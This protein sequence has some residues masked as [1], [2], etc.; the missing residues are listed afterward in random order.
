MSEGKDYLA[1]VVSDLQVLSEKCSRDIKDKQ[2]VNNELYLNEYNR[3]LEEAKK[4]Q[5]DNVADINPISMKH[6]GYD[7]RADNDFARLYEVD[8][9]TTKLLAR[10]KP[11]KE[12]ESKEEVLSNLERIFKRFHIVARQLRDRYESRLTLDIKDEYD[13]QDLL[14]SLLQIF[15]EDIR[16]E[17]WTPSYAGS[18]SRMDFLLKDEQVVVEVKKTGDKLRDKQIGSQLIDDIARYGEHPDCRTLVCFVYDPE[19]IIANP[20]GLENDL[21]KQSNE[22]LDVNVY[23]FP[24]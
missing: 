21:H 22:R 3:L 8:A 13:V 2:W 23:V 7:S 14:H 20:V 1:T 24:K 6:Y 15:Y 5:P 4:A 11:R 19:G 9:A 12:H 10:F 17:E 18:T 16:P